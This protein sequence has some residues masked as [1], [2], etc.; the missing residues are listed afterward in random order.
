MSCAAC[1][2]GA[3]QVGT[4]KGTY[5]DLHGYRTYIAEPPKPHP[6]G[7]VILYLPDFFS[8]KLVNNKLL[9]DL[10][11]ERVGCTVIFPDIVP[12]GGSDA[13]YLPCFER[14]LDRDAPWYSRIWAFVQILPIIHMFFTASPEGAYR[15]V[16]RYARALRSQLPEKAKLGVVGFCWGGYGS[17]HLCKETTVTGGRKPLI[18]AQFCGHPSKLDTP[19]D[20]VEAIETF[21]VPYSVAVGEIDMQFGGAKAAE[22]EALLRSK[23]QGNGDDRTYQ[24]VVHP[25]AHHGFCLRAKDNVA[26]DKEGMD[27]SAD[28]AVAW[29]SK[30]LA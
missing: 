7:S 22:T 25:G 4:P 23:G 17:T 26:A 8:H 1:F 15:E 20:I 12:G 6:L 16:L 30:Y 28:Q 2:S 9:A 19:K 24:I 3:V 14:L 13:A 18:N 21:K 11:A 5:K 10:Y 27:K 29:L